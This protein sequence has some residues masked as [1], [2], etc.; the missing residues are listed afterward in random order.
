MAGSVRFEPATQYGPFHR[1]MVLLTFGCPAFSEQRVCWRKAI[2]MF[3]LFL[4]AALQC[5]L[6]SLDF[7]LMQLLFEFT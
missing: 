7:V 3:S 1:I 2:T 6:F 4:S 5:Q